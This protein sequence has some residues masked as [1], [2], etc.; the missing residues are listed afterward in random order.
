MPS[1]P[2]WLKQHLLQDPSHSQAVSSLFRALVSLWRYLII[3]M[4]TAYLH[5]LEWRIQEERDCL[6]HCSL[7][8]SKNSALHKEG[9]Q[10]MWMTDQVKGALPFHW[11]PMGPD[12]LASIWSRV[13]GISTLLHSPNPSTTRV[14]WQGFILS[15]LFLS[16]VLL[17]WDVVFL[18]MEVIQ[19]MP[20]QLNCVSMFP[21]N[22][23]EL[24]GCIAQWEGP[25][26]LWSVGDWNEK[27]VCSVSLQDFRCSSW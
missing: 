4:L 20:G 27:W 19:A 13:I 22:W 8:A 23:A 15:Y 21:T 14:F 3:S 17:P 1:R 16:H 25:F 10:R 24:S 2:F 5:S 26:E 18:L 7:P 11:Y 6:I 12:S 9:T